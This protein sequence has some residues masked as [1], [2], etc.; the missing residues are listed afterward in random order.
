M[1]AQS[2]LS[3]KDLKKR[4]FFYLKKM[5]SW[6]TASQAHRNKDSEVGSG[7]SGLYSSLLMLFNLRH[8]LFWASVSPE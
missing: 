4:T 7:Q 3:M 5:L 1:S 8:L 2:L 6:L